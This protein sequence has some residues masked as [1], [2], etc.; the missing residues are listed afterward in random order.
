MRAL[1]AGAGA[2]V[3]SISR[4]AA[5]VQLSLEST[6][7]NSLP[8]SLRITIH[9]EFKTANVYI[10]GKFPPILCH[11]TQSSIKCGVSSQRNLF[12]F[13]AHSAY[14]NV[15]QQKVPYLNIS[16]QNRVEFNCFAIKQCCLVLTVVGP[17]R[18]ATSQMVDDQQ[19]VDPILFPLIG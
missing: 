18:L 12:H 19:N 6:R 3:T 5:L 4:G 10:C 13:S 1:K 2:N 16:R 9:P 7:R 17:K 15:S 11:D 14:F 8:N